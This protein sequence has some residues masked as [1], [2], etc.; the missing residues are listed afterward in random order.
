M[1][2]AWSALPAYSLTH[3]ALVA[4]SVTLRAIL[5]GWSLTC[6]QMW[7]ATCY[8]HRAPTPSRGVEGAVA[9]SARSRC[10]PPARCVCKPHRCSHRTAQPRANV[11][12]SRR[13]PRTEASAMRC[14]PAA[15]STRMP[16]S[17]P[18]PRTCTQAWPP[19]G[20]S[21][22]SHQ[23]DQVTGTTICV[24]P[25]KPR[26]TDVS[27]SSSLTTVDGRRH[28]DRTTC[29]SQVGQRFPATTFVS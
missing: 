23:R 29:H 16:C 13:P 27:N 10:Q 22:K 19:S 1:R 17:Q 6:G 2:E 20:Y 4:H 21:E 8:I 25:R 28:C 15:R 9:C 26:D 11:R 5:T 7:R 18:R 14:E 24:V 12:R 3:D